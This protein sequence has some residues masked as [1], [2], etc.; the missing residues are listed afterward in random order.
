MFASSFCAPCRLCRQ[1]IF[2]CV[3]THK[4][5]LIAYEKK[6]RAQEKLKVHLINSTES[7]HKF[8][9]YMFKK[10]VASLESK[11]YFHN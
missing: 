6:K 5:E 7:A 11:T 10:K 3:K 4:Q 8:D 2:N 9:K 1:R